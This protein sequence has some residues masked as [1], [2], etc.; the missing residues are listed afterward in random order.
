[1][2]IVS[3]FFFLLLAI[4]Y[5]MIVGSF[6]YR[7]R[8]GLYI[9][10][11]GFAIAIIAGIFLQAMDPPAPKTFTRSESTRFSKYQKN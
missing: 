8:K 11:S 2:T 3:V 1:M 4:G 6:F 9:F 5:C 10:V 7:T